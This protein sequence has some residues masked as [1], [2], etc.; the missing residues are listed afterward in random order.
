MTAE[1]VAATINALAGPEERLERAVGVRRRAVEGLGARRPTRPRSSS[2]STRRTATSRTCSAR[3]T[4]TRSSSRR[5]STRDVGEDVPG[6]R[7]VE[8]REVHARTRASPTSRTPTTGTR[9]GSPKPDRQR[10]QVLRQGAGRRSWRSSAATSTSSPTSRRPAARRCSTTRTSRSSSCARRVHRQIHMRNDKEPFDD[11]RVRQALAL[12]VD[13]D[14]ARQRPPRGQGGLRQRQPVRAGVPVDRQERRRSA[15]RTSR[16]P[17]RCMQRPA[18]AARQPRSTRGTASRCPTSPSCS[19]TTPRRSGINAQAERHARGHVLRRRGLRQVA[20]AGLDHRHHRLR[21][22]RRAERVPRRAAQSKGTWNAAHFKNKTY[23]SSVQ[24]LRRGARP[25]A[26]SGRRR[27]RSRSC[28]STRRRSSS[29]TSTSSSR[30]RRRT[31]ATWRCPPWATS[32]SRRP[33]FTSAA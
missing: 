29:P 20:V 18:S 7:P 19:R 6:H 9:R 11:K 5:T 15:S 32:T 26:R 1:D 23:D 31:S 22:P 2:S 30:G 3:T 14:G 13:R 24:G 28:C 25:P 4:T 12:A 16:R 21:P 17:R 10:G 27:R 8:A 33:G